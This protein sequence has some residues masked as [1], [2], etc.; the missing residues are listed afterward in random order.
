VQPVDC[1]E[2]RVILC[3]TFDKRA[4][5][6]DLTALKATLIKS[7]RIL[8]S[9]E[10]TGAFDFITEVRAP[11]MPSYQ[12]WL[13][14]A[15]EPL[16]RLAANVETSFVC[17][18]FIRRPEEDCC[19]WV[20]SRGALRRIECSL[21]DKIQAEGDYIHIHSRGRQWMLHTTLRA[22][23]ERV[24]EKNFVQIN[25]SL[26]VRCGFIDRLRRDGRN[27]IAD[28][29]D[30]TRARVARSHLASTRAALRISPPLPTLASSEAKQAHRSPKVF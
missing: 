13:Q 9:V 18:R 22:M 27:Y 5:P 28:L 20:P 21:I 1:D 12:K 10:T 6:A 3:I 8:H 11:D 15:A 16:A 29:Q 25:R 30:G 14:Q 2:L 19:V 7:E 26:I 4:P 24:S 17:K 23:R